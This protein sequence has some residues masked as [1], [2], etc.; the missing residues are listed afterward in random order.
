MTQLKCDAIHCISNR[1]GRCCRP[2]IQVGGANATELQQTC[3]ES[4]RYVES[5]SNAVDYSHVNE[6]MPIRC[7]AANCVYNRNYECVADAIQMVGR[8]AQKMEQTACETFRCEN[9][10]K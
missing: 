1:E 2:D 3:C 4:F 10:C 7:D 5:Q 9:N 6:A 8:S